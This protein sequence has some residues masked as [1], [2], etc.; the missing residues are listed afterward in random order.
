MPMLVP[1][2]SHDP[3]SH[4]A[5]HFNHLDLRNAVMSLALCN[6]DVNT[7]G[8]TGP[9]SHGIPHFSC[10]DVRNVMMALI[11]PSVPCDPDTNANDVI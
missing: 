7:N 2:V 1:F 11:T 4:I 3:Q 10:L 8:V 6:A 5:L 9:K